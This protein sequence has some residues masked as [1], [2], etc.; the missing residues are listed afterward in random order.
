MEGLMT[1]SEKIVKEQLKELRDNTE[2]IK[3][4]AKEIKPCSQCVHLQGGVMVPS[5]HVCQSD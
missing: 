3:E 4:L 2:K 1:V 5:T